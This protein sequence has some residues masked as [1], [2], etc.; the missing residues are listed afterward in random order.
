MG[1]GVGDQPAGVYRSRS[2]SLP[3][4]RSRYLGTGCG[5]WSWASD[6]TDTQRGPPW[7]RPEPPRSGFS[8]PTHAPTGAVDVGG[9]ARRQEFTPTA[10][11]SDDGGRRPSAS[12]RSGLCQ[13][14]PP[15]LAPGRPS[16]GRGGCGPRGKAD[17]DEGD[18]AGHHRSGRPKVNVDKVDGVSR[19]HT[20]WHAPSASAGQDKKREMRRVLRAMV[21]RL[22]RDLS[23]R[24]RA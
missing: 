7:L 3:I 14:A 23:P 18:H 12:R 20:G 10:A 21:N 15:V 22:N 17:E 9:T 11:G 8:A 2:L 5:P 16:P 6:M 1:G 4:S 24:L 13:G 19:R